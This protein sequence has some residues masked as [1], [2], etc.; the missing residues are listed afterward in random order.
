[1]RA[2]LAA[3]ALAFLMAGS[4]A[5]TAQGVL[6]VGSTSYP[7]SLD[8]ATSG[9]GS[10]HPYLYLIYDRLVDADRAT[11][12]L[13]PGLATAWKFSDD[14][15]KLEMSLR[16]GVV[17]QDGTPFNA[18]AVV[19][20]IKRYQ[21]KG[22]QTDLKI[23]SNV[24]A[25][26][27]YKVVFTLANPD[28]SLPAILADRG[29]MIVSPTAVSKHGDGFPRNPVGTGPY[30]VDSTVQGASVKYSR[31]DGYWG[32]KPALDG[33][34]WT[35]FTEVIALENAAT[36]GQLDIAMQIPAR[37]VP[38]L[39]NGTGYK[40][41]S[42]PSLEVTLMMLNG[43]KAPVNSKAVREAISRAINRD[44]ILVATNN[45]AGAVA[46]QLLP[47]TSPYYSEEVASKYG[48]DLNRAKQ[49][50]QEA[51]QS[52]VSLECTYF[53]GLGYEIAGPLMI[54]NLAQ[55]G[56]KLTLV[57]KT[58][59]QGVTDMAAGKL[60]CFLTRWTGRPD[61]AMTLFGVFD[62]RGFANYGKNAIGVDALMDQMLA[63]SEPTKRVALGKQIA[64]LGAQDPLSIPLIY[65]PAV[66]LVGS[67][68][69]GY[70][71]N[72]LGKQDLRSV[73]LR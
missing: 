69:D 65:Q 59:A 46:T 50:M 16:Q 12:E 25:A 7:T 26:E 24:E 3:A 14:G 29:G 64:L 13:K 58:L 63:T 48:Y 42:G 31:F 21:Q 66:V 32:G 5:A 22:V 56:I 67:K 68:V 45:G 49:L 52:N 37:D 41:S 10:D 6:R 20:S 33:V 43:T 30:K 51:K 4:Q 47:S 17:F 8:P 44:D 15:R 27:P 2:G 28:S 1:M 54:E 57:E 70:T 60:P 40:V 34:N 53:A 39:Q 11:G 18:D 72:Y 19:A 55:I 73:S 35:T 62:S 23:V 36:T 61:P 71:P 9:G 38:A